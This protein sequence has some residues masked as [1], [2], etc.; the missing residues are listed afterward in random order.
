MDEVIA[1]QGTLLW[2]PLPVV[3]HSDIKTKLFGF[4]KTLCGK[5][6]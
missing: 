3:Y 5:G 6:L 4:N 2:N 1:T